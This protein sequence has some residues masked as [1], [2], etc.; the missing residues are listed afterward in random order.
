VGNDMLDNVSLAA[1]SFFNMDS[2]ENDE[3]SPGDAI[4]AGT[5]LRNSLVCDFEAIMFCRKENMPSRKNLIVSFILAYAIYLLVS[6]ILH[7]TMIT[8]VVGPAWRIFGLGFMVPWMAFQ[9]AYGVGPSCFPMIPTCLLQDA[10]LFVEQLMPMRIQWPASLQEVPGCAADP[11]LRAS[12]IRCMRSCR[13]APFHFRSWESSLSWMVCSLVNEC[14]TIPVPDIVKSFS[15][16]HIAMANHSDVIQ[17]AYPALM[18][19]EPRAEDTDV[20]HGHQFCFFVT[21]GQLLPYVFLLIALVY[22]IVQ[23]LML[24]FLLVSAGFQFAWQAIAYTHVD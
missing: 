23:I 16:L 3:D 2:N 21:L 7:A 12:G 4:T 8:S 15:D 24:P 6:L 22:G 19:Q 1:A 20:W 17:R 10:I 5:I 13:D 18:N 11:A 14:H 9:F